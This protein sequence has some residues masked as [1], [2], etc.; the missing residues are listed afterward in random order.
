MDDYLVRVMSKEVGIRGFACLAT[1]LVAEA[2]RRHR[3]P[4][5][6]TIAL[7]EGLIGGV[8]LGTLLKVGHRIAIKFVG[9][10]SQRKILVEANN[11]GKIRGY[12]TLPESDPLLNGLEEPD[13]LFFE[14][15]GQLSVVKDLR[16]RNLYESTVSLTGNG[17]VADFNNYLNLS[18]QI[19]SVVEAGVILSET[20]PGPA[21]VVSAGGLLLQALPP[22]EENVV[23]DFAN[24]IQELPPIEAMVKSGHTPETILAAIF[25][26]IPYEILEVIPLAFRCSCSRERSQK[27]L[28]SLGREELIHLLETEGKASVD[29]HFCYE[30][31]EFD[32]DD[33]SELI[34]M[35]PK[36]TGEDFG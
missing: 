13:N 32:S 23:R 5:A 3:T 12:V 15:D 18:E 33:L 11:I 27:A 36:E 14:Q 1:N 20:E 19:P 25:G 4:P 24:R 7:G 9:N 22:Y 28:I 29:C 35:F 30:K 17:I 2:A 16:L 10:Q 31:Y 26:E 34:Q 6:A 8:L 21:G